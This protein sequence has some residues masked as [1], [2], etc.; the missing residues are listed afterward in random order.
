MRV[1]ISR[2]CRRKR[3]L[4]PPA[5]SSLWTPVCIHENDWGQVK[6]LEKA[7]LCVI[8][9][10]RGQ[11][12]TLWERQRLH[13]DPPSIWN[14]SVKML[15]EGQQTLSSSGHRCRPVVR[16]KGNI[17]VSLPLK[18]EQETLLLLDCGDSSQWR[19]PG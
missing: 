11:P 16:S 2:R 18:E 7:F 12:P 5:G 17:K 6:R 14:N 3:S 4:H 9:A 1:Q 8:Q 10:G 15:A 19:K 13:P